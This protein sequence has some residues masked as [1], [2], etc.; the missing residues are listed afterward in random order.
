MAYHWQTGDDWHDLN[1]KLIEVNCEVV[2]NQSGYLAIGKVVAIKPD[3]KYP[4]R[5][6]V[7]K[8]ADR[9]RRYA[10]TRIAK[11]RHSTSVMVLS[12]PDEMSFDEFQE[13]YAS[14]TKPHELRFK[15]HDDMGDWLK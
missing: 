11:V 5:I 12:S 1:G 13:R 6:R 8:S 10:D 9:S 2:F 3:E 15:R 4:I 7:T 14:G